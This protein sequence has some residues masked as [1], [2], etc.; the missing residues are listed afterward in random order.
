MNL[1][2]NLRKSAG[3]SGLIILL[4]LAAAVTGLGLRFH[5]NMKDA[6]DFAQ[7]FICMGAVVL[8]S[9][10]Y[11]AARHSL[12][13]GIALGLVALNDQLLTLAV[14][15]LVAIL[16]PQSQS[17]PL[18]IIL[19]IAFTYCQNMPVLRAAINLRA[20]TS[21]RETDNAAVIRQ[22]LQETRPLRR[23]SAGAALLLLLAGAISGNG[24]MAASLVPV[25]AGLLVSLFSA[26]FLMPQLWRMSAEKWGGRK[27]SR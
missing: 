2:N 5:A 21:M 8:F 7:L 4:G 24:L 15:S 3:L 6:V 13:A 25:L 26:H 23:L 22:A 20:A 1:D 18:M 17:L 14:V 11:G 9:F 27:A 10:L 16:L 12:G 19:T